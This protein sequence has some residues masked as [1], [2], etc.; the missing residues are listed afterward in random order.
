M[1]VGQ[2]EKLF[3]IRLKEHPKDVF[4]GDCETS[5]LAE[6]VM[7]T[8]HETDWTNNTVLA[9]CRFLDQHLYL[10][11]KVYVHTPTTEWS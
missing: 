11:V 7:I 9:S 8:G 2:T 10:R 4:I 5:T 3:T 1:Y 6:H